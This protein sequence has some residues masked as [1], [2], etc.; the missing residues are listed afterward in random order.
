MCLELNFSQYITIEKKLVI[1]F[2]TFLYKKGERA[3]KK[4][5]FFRYNNEQKS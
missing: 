5:R 4:M 1:Y 2:I 3:K